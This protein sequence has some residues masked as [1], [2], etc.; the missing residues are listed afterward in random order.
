MTKR[1]RAAA[2]GVR[3]RARKRPCPPG[4]FAYNTPS[5]RPGVT[6][7]GRL[8]RDPTRLSSVKGHCGACPGVRLKGIPQ[9]AKQ[10]PPNSD[11]PQP[12]LG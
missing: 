12:T 6:S 7:V 3:S 8:R 4:R 5:P 11:A 1:R 10:S 2:R 9:R